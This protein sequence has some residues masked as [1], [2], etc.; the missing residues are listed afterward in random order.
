MKKLTWITNIHLQ[1]FLGM[2]GIWPVEEDC[3]TDAAGYKPSEKLAEAI[4]SFEI[5]YYHFKNKY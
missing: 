4:E 3:I 1:N 2:H 5:R